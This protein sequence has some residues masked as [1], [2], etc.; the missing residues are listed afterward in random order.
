[1]NIIVAHLI[2]HPKPPL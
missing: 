2:H 1:L